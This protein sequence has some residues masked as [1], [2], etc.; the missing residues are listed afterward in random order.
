M[1]KNINQ[2]YSWH[3]IE[4]QH[5]CPN[6]EL[7][8]WWLALPLVADSQWYISLCFTSKGITTASFLSITRQL[9]VRMVRFIIKVL[10]RAQRHSTKK[11]HVALVLSI[12]MMWITV[13]SVLHLPGAH[14]LWCSHIWE[15]LATSFKPT[16]FLKFH[17][18]SLEVLQCSHWSGFHDT[19]PSPLECRK[20]HY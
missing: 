3:I 16:G 18:W 6:L 11:R 9:M 14:D 19:I 13:L 10:G 17:I 4:T 1:W 2:I 5:K 12:K 8:I 20:Q 7:F 15:Y